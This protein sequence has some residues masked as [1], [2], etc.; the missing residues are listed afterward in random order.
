M[1]GVARIFLNDGRIR[2]GWRFGMFLVLYFAGGKALDFVASKFQ[3]PDPGMTSSGLLLFEIED[4]ALVAAVTWVMSRM[5]RERFS[6]YGLPLVRGAG[7]LFSKGIIWGVIPSIVIVIPI[8]L[9]GGCSFHG[10]AVHGSGLAVS[11][12]GW[13]LAFLGV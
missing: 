2:P 6:S 10:L 4:F 12:L 1:N 5:E 7:L 13:A 3:Q 9:V 11:A 8:Y